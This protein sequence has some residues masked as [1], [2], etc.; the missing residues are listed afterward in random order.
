VSISFPTAISNWATDATGAVYRWVDGRAPWERV[1]TT[2][3]PPWQTNLV[4][5]PGNPGGCPKVDPLGVH[6]SPD[7]AARDFVRATRGW[8]DETLVASYP[9][10][11]PGG[12]FGSVFATNVARQCGRALADASYGVELTNP[13]VT[14]DNSRSTALVVAPIGGE[15]KVWGF[16]R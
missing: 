11:Q 14:Q 9:V 2:P 10:T 1:D 15:W 4:A 6:S 3:Q 16:Y 13:S 5:V 7:Q 12:Q 8:S